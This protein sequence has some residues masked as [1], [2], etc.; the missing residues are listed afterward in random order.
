MRIRSPDYSAIGEPIDYFEG[1]GRGPAPPL[2]GNVLVFLRQH[3]CA[4]Q[5][6]ALQNRSHHRYVLLYNLATAGHVH[7]DH[8]DLPLTPDQALLVFP[9]QFHHFTQLATSHLCWMVCTFELNSP[10]VFMPLR[11]QVVSLG[12]TAREARDQLVHQWLAC[13]SANAI[14]ETEELSLRVDVLRALLSLLRDLPVTA[15]PPSRSPHSLLRQVNQ[16]LITMR[17][18][19]FTIADLAERVGQY[20]ST[21]RSR[22]KQNAGIPLGAYILNY[23]I[24]RAMSLL[25]NTGRSL[26]DI[27]EETGFGS[28]Q[29]FSRGFKR[30]TGFSPRTYR[31][32]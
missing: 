8:L 17:G 20:E 26:A 11:D 2:P 9:Y 15:P 21:L 25:R 22:F 10:E 29:S 13:R 3:R 7:V 5:Q 30:A 32:I 18:R 28:P 4:L 1:L 14:A 19:P 23:R 6:Q 12:A 27:A 31:N 24:N 16:A